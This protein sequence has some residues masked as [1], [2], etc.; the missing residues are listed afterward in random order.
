MF[1]L[2]RTIPESV[3][4]LVAKQRFKDAEHVLLKAAKFNG[5]QLPEDPLKAKKKS[6]EEIGRQTS[7]MSTRYTICDIFRMKE[8]CKR[9]LILFYIW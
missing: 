9:S 5:V 4:W 7:V 6:L 3:R 1:A 2:C 8:L